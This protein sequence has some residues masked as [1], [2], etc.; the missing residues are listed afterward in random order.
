MMDKKRVRETLDT[1]VDTW[2]SDNSWFRA[3]PAWVRGQI[4]FAFMI[5]AITLSEKERMLQ[6]VSEA[7]GEDLT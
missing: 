6:R 2:L 3:D 4:Y 1:V 7:K 5:G